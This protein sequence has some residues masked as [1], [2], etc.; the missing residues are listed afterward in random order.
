MRRGCR[1]VFRRLAGAPGG[2][3][4]A[5]VGTRTRTRP[6]ESGRPSYVT[7]DGYRRLEEEAHRLW[8]EDRPRMARAV[9]VAAAEGDRSENA[10]YQYSKRK[11]AEID[12]R[13]RFLG[14]RLEVLTI[15]SERPPEDGRVYFGSWVT[16]VDERG[17]ESTYRIVGPDETDAEAGWISIDSPV[18]KAMLRK[19]EGD[20][21]EVRRPRSTVL[22]EIVRVAS[23]PPSP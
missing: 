3:H 12:R 17:A 1:R 4:A 22:L 19:E 13:L 2:D 20:E 9:Q 7:A 14:K 21:V 15:V 8:T 18:A 23:S 6:D 16:V 5:R 10:E 11:L